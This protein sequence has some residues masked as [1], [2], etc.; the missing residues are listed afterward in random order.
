MNRPAEIDRVLE[1]WLLDG[2]S[3]MPDRL[4]ESV[5]DQVDRTSQRR[6]A[7]LQ[8]RFTDM[9]PT[10]RWLAAGAAAVLLAAVG[11]MTFGRD[12][13]V[14]PGGPTASPSAS[15]SSSPAPG[16]PAELRYGFLAE[17]RSQPPAP[18]GQDRSI[19]E[20]DA[21]TFT[22]N[23][24]LLTSDA[25][26]PTADSIMLVARP[27]VDDCAG[28]DEGTYTW[29]ASPGG[30]KVTFTLV[31]DDCAARAAV[32]PGE[33]LRSDCPDSGN[34]CLGDLEPGRY[35]SHYIDP[36]VAPG[37]DWRPRFGAISYEVPGGWANNGD[38]PTEYT[39]VPVDAD[40][41]WTGIYVVTDIVIVSEED[42]CSETPDSNVGRTADAMVAWLADA[43][44]IVSTE[45]EGVEIGGLSG[46][47]LDLSMDPSWTETCPFSNGQPTR[48]LFTDSQPGAGLQWNVSGE[49][50]MRLYVLDL[51]DGRSMV[52]NIEAPDQ[53]AYESMID[54]A[55]AIVESMAFP[56]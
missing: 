26:A 25:S 43:P 36:F 28:G 47:A 46:Y 19:L 5:L 2:P 56:R 18:A 17:F 8:L 10:I 21:T 42:H 40:A 44:G 12:P 41:P 23:G 14:G 15:G 55:T 16:V 45:P 13:G 52:V 39:L 9:T 50:R 33:W 1:V 27:G 35:S 4:F 32:I 7:R 48:G 22:Y 6:L 29:S 20:F 54:E 53:A 31:K 30:A 37:V 34:F 51:G 38:W 49:T 24:T 3:R 11:F